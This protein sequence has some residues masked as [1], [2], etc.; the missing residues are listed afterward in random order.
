MTKSTDWS[1]LFLY[2]LW[3]FRIFEHLIQELR[4]RHSN[5]V[6]FRTRNALKERLFGRFIV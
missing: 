2:C 1:S 3:S 5:K 6:T 4:F